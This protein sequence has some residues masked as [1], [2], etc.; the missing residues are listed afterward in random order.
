MYFCSKVMLPLKHVKYALIECLLFLNFFIER[1]VVVILL[2]PMWSEA[3]EQSLD[4]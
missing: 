4:E 3:V 2:K 1:H